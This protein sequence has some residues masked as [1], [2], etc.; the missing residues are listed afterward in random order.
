MLDAWSL[1]E[2]PSIVGPQIQQ[3][4]LVQA[5]KQHELHPSVAGDLHAYSM[6]LAEMQEPSSGQTWTRSKWNCKQTAAG[7]RR[8]CQ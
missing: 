3:C 6:C 5:V 7:K 2:Q 4:Q 1:P 8:S